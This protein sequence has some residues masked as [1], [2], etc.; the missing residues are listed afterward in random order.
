MNILT[1]KK[2]KQVLKNGLYIELQN[3]ITHLFL[4]TKLMPNKLCK[5]F[6]LVVAYS[7]AAEWL[8]SSRLMFKP[9]SINRYPAQSS[10]L[11]K[12]ILF[13][14]KF[15]LSVRTTRLCEELITCIMR[16]YMYNAVCVGP[17]T[18][19]L[20]C[21]VGDHRTKPSYSIAWVGKGTTRHRFARSVPKSK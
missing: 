19:C 13:I 1:H 21:T 18:W 8:L 9:H 12:L 20:S 11:Q 10:I 5:K 2:Y 6:F 15:L 17:I 4:I 14:K 16:F 3:F 7:A